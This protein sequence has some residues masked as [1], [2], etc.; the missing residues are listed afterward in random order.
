MSTAASQAFFGFGDSHKAVQ[1]ENGVVTIPLSGVSD[2][3]AHYY[4]YRHGGKD[5]KF[6]VMQSRD[7]TM[8]A[9]FDACDVC[10]HA[11]KGYSQDDDFM[12]CKNCGMRFHSSKINV[13][14]GGCNPAPLKRSTDKDNLFIAVE[15]IIPGGRFF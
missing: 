12:I 1:A 7:G 4:T 11:E 15:D 6:F 14:S 3:K 10:Y 13:V 5:I 9:A 8:R 2:G